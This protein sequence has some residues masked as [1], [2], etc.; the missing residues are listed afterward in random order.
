VLRKL[1]SLGVST[2]DQRRHI[3]W[4]IGAAAV[5]VTLA[6]LLD[7]FLILQTYS[8]FNTKAGKLRLLYEANPMS[9]VVEQAGGMASSGYERIMDIKRARFARAGDRALTII[10]VTGWG[11]NEARQH[12]NGD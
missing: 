12:S 1:N 9:F 6:A 5:A 4:D 8:R 10:A 11:Q 2:E 7:A 3:A